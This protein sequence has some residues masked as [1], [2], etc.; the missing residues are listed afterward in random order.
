M[1]IISLINY[2]INSLS[3]SLSTFLDAIRLL[4]IG[5]AESVFRELKPGRVRH[6]VVYL[7]LVSIPILIGYYIYLSLYQAKP[8]PSEIALKVALRYYLIAFTT[9]MVLG[10]VIYLF[11]QRLV[12]TKVTHQEGLTIFAYALTPALL[13][14][15]FRISAKGIPDPW[16][17]HLVLIAYS[18]YLCYK[19]L[20]T[21]FGVDYVTVPFVFL[22]LVGILNAV[23]VFKIVSII[24]GIPD[25]YG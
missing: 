8:Y 6:L 17:L 7:L 25:G 11:D 19:G 9:P 16:I 4:N 14:G 5:W 24:L 13:S 23:A 12:K 18:I 21:R 20:A 15:F 22:I 2:V 1:I 10:Y 3:Y